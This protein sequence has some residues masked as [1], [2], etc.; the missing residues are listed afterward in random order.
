MPDTQT[1]NLLLT[2]Q[3]QGGNDNTWGIIL[4]GNQDIIDAKLGNTTAITTTGGTTTLSNDEERVAHIAV[5]GTLV[6]NA[7]I[8][9]SGRGG[10]WIVANDTA[11]AF[12]VTCKVSGQTGVQVAQGTATLVWCNGTDI[13]LG[14]PTATLAADPA[15]QLSADLDTN[16]HNIKFATGKGINDDA[17]NEQIVFHKT[18]SAVVQI[19]ITNAATGNPPQIAAEGGDTDI[20]LLLAGKGTGGVVANF[21]QATGLGL[22]DSDSSH[23]LKLK[24]SSNLTQQRTLDIK[25]GDADRTVTLSG[26][27]TVSGAATLPAG[28]A[29]VAGNNLSDVNNAAT[30]FGNIKQAASDSATGVM[31]IADQPEM[32]AASDTQKAVTPGRQHFHPGHPKAAGR[33]ASAGGITGTAHNVVSISRNSTGNYTVTLT[34]P[35]ADTNYWVVATTITGSGFESIFVISISSE[36]VFTLQV[37]DNTGSARDAAFGFAVY[38]DM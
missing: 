20:D 10:F 7:T 38:G 26:D 21:K 29:L 14:V 18:A 30:A 28:T 31:E 32:E 35:M 15:P 9:F 2:D 37:H 27:L 23:A 34:N 33:G 6:S 8:V 17:G 16:G 19:G 3:A 24:T 13:R 11:G 25:P 5:D 12:T 1:P 22:L 4:N 36:S